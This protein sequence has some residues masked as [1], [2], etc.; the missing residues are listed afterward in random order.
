[1]KSAMKVGGEYQ[2]KRIGRRQW[3]N[4]AAN[5]RLNESRVID[6][7]MAVIE[8]LPSAIDAVAGRTINDGLDA[9]VIERLQEGI[10]QRTARCLAMLTSSG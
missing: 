9:S 5:S 10:R 7:V 8:Q 2:I 3:A 6:T 4:L 1:M